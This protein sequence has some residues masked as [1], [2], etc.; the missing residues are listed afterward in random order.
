MNWISS[1]M[2]T[3]ATPLRRH[4]VLFMLV[5]CLA[6]PSVAW[7]WLVSPALAASNTRAKSRAA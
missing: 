4:A 7:G 6:V 3:P 1:H 5:L 2:T